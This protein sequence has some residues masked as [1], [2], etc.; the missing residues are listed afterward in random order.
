MRRLL[1][2]AVLAALALLAAACTLTQ[3]AY[4][5]IALAYNNAPPMLSWMVADYVDM[6][7]QQKE[8]VRERF[9]RA[10]A[11]HRQ[12]QLPEYRRFL[13]KVLVQAEDNITVEEAAAAHRELRTYYH[14]AVERLLPDMADF[15]LG[16]DSVQVKQM[17]RR[18]AKDNRKMV[19]DATEQTGEERLDK[20]VERFTTHLEQFVGGSLTEEQRRMVVGYVSAQPELVDE[21]LAD[22]RFRQERILGVVR[23][24]PPRDEAIAALRRIFIDPEGWRN[25]G[26]LTK[27]W[28][29]DQ[30]MFDLISRLSGSLNPDQRAAF[31]K[32]VRGF[33]RDITEI[34]AAKAG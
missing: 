7:E 26:Y 3:L 29:R 22:R 6:S 21:R 17:E 20:R 11:W 19:S 33:M 14:R 30:A 15:L 34:S 5:N 16:L 23:D 18:F 13:E 31:Q 12:Q 25:P 32:R 8:F 9:D 24:K 10:F 2:Y 4:S 28:Q 27:L 1:D